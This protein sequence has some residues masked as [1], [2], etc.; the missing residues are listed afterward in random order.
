MF[1]HLHVHSHYSLLD[2]LPKIDELIAK[3][4]N[5]KMKALALTDHGVMY[6]VIEFYKKAKEAGIK[7]IIGLEAYLAPNGRFSKR[8]KIDDKPFHLTLLAK[9]E[10]GYKNL[11][12]L[13]TLGHL[14]GFYYKPRIDLELLKLYS[15]GLI[16]LSGCLQGEVPQAILTHQEKELTKI[17]STY[18]EIFKD[19]FYLELQAHDF[20]EQ[21]KVNKEL[22]FLAKK[23]NLKLVA[24]NDVHYL[25]Q[26]EA[27]IQDT[28]LCLQTKKKLDD[29]ERLKMASND[30]HLRSEEEM[31]RLFK[32]NLEAI[33][34]TQEIVEKCNL[35]IELGK[36]K[37]PKFLLAE[38]ENADNYLKKLCLEKLKEKYPKPGKEVF[39]RL[40][41]EL[42]VIK[43]T[44]FAT[45][46]LIVHDFVEWA[47]INKIAVGPGR[48]SAASSIVSYLLG[49]TSID[50][51]KYDL[52][53][54]RFLTTERISAPDIDLDFADTRRDEVI[55]YIENKYGKENVAQIITFGTMAA[56][57]AVR[58]VGR[59]LG[60]PYNFCD[61]L[62]KMIP[63]FLSL[64]EALKRVRDLRETY[65]ESP[66]ARK[67]IE[68]AKKLEGV[69]RHASTHACGIVITP[70]NLNNYLPTQYDV[71][72]EKRVLVSQYSM[73]SI[74][75]LG[76]LKIDLL[77]LK[78]L[79][80]LETTIKLIE[81]Q[82][83]KLE[84]EKIPFNDKKTFE[85]L[86]KG[87]TVGVFQ[88][89]GSGVRKYLVELQ[90]ID[91]EDIIAMVA[92]YR[93]G[94]MELI[95]KYVAGRYT[96]KISYL[97]P[98]L[99]PILEK[100][101]GVAVYQEQILEIAKELAGFTLSE[102]DVLRKAIG[103]K[104]PGLLKEQREKFIEGCVANRIERKIA[105]EIFNFMEPFAGY[106]FNRCLAG[107]TEIT[108]ALTGKVFTIEEIYKKKSFSSSVL[109]C[110]KN[111]KLKKSKIKK[112]FYNGIKPV[113]EV[114]TRLGRKIKATL[115]HPFLTIKGWEILK[116]LKIGDQIAVP[117]FLPLLNKK[118]Y[119]IKNYQLII[120]GYLLAKGNLCHPHGF[121]F[122][123]SDKKEREDYLKA[124]K[125][126]KNTK[127]K[128]DKKNRKRNPSIYASRI[129]PKEK[130]EAIEWIKNIGL[131]YKKAIGKEF[132][133]FIFQL[134]KEQLSLLLGKLFQGDG[135]INLK[136]RS[137]QIFYATSSYKLAKQLQH[138]FL[139]LGI[140]SKL[141]DKKFKY[142]K[143]IKRGYTLTITQY[144]NI[145]NFAETIGKY[146]IGTKKKMVDKILRTHPILTN[147]LNKNAARGSKDTVPSKIRKLIISEI[148]SKYSSLKELAK[149]NKIAYRLFFNDKKKKGY[150]RET[151]EIIGK[152][153]KSKLIL[154]FAR[155]DI[156]WDAIREIKYLGKAP[157]FDLNINPSHNYVANDIIVHNSHAVC[158]ATIAYQT[159]YLKTHW[160]VEFMTALLISDAGDLDRMAIEIEECRRLGI[161]ISP[162]DVNE[163]E[164]NFA[165]VEKDGKKAIRFGLMAIKNVG[166]NVAKAII[167]ERNENGIY[168]NLTDF[169]S[170]VPLQYL[171]K[172][173]LESLI[174][175]GALD[176]FNERGSLLENLNKFLEFAKQSQKE[177]KTP[178]KTLFG[179]LGSQSFSFLHLK[180]TKNLSS[181][182]ILSLEKEFL[183]LYVS[184]H[185]LQNLKENLEK[186]KTI[187]C[188]KL[189][190]FKENQ[191]VRVAGVITKIEKVITN[192]QEPMLF[193]KIED[194]SGSVEI[195]V[196]PSLLRELTL[197]WQENKIIL[198][199]GRVSE[200]EGEPKIIGLKAKEISI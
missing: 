20:P 86:R 76:L 164:E 126:F 190:E 119:P 10:E 150:L 131:K 127:G 97:H 173:S 56:R 64:D 23:F 22:I 73:Y 196:F 103:K 68:M 1:T 192:S 141:N 70:E 84:I 157:T 89:E 65:L 40:D 90:P 51:L 147:K 59:V 43:K 181:Q 109:S 26:E 61:K 139:R 47:K 19:D 177:K 165:I 88:L 37:F 151:L 182:E 135:C 45:Y 187:P 130:S 38:G 39:E 189:I 5:E 186:E 15:N 194:L 108:E 178:Q 136:R 138:L 13:T 55:H 120:L 18:K 99:K 171:N 44:G 175:G 198:V 48:G 124:L 107:D 153:L 180:N 46:F 98:K 58:D 92:L 146:L 167:K 74:E 114:T 168:Q 174:K 100:T 25:E 81:N 69:A 4:K 60:L 142:H 80:L 123:S 199:E 79:T 179:N 155:S 144:E 137:P 71:S 78:N 72:Q 104:I 35:E 16:A 125:K 96:K 49:I 140:I 154:N 17:I 166:E 134:N 129:N 193:V 111:L 50:P 21:I 163:S 112:I 156:Y 87:E 102:A 113:Y 116:N 148:K 33:S 145:K 30:F 159:A 191:I 41:Y 3:A 7:P 82:G 93:P 24:T 152:T 200:K 85:L 36:I 115:N 188:A 132:P 117:R 143:G 105:E 95:P 197:L 57:V 52:I 31:I 94:P 53:F 183:G 172:K 32:E 66:E 83:K 162:P 176:R 133:S 160:P 11:I 161:E 149:K 170:R 128:I 195:L 158:Y 42:E 28:L 118:S 184:G 14:E 8:V 62:A 29:R 34:I 6:G 106:A 121:Y 67:V 91:F 169:L 27:E 9:N 110:H 63:P 185:P 77:G 122:Y 54:E 12:K 101:Y 75:D 2:G